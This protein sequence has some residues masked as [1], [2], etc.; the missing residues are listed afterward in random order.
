CETKPGDVH[1]RPG[2]PM[3][4]G[5]PLRVGE[6]DLPGG[7]W[8][9]QVGVDHAARGVPRVDVEGGRLARGP[10]CRGREE[11]NEACAAHGY[12]LKAASAADRPPARARSATTR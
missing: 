2:G 9:R 7:D 4:A 5:D 12:F 1:D 3:F 11:G 8:D 6:R 10:R